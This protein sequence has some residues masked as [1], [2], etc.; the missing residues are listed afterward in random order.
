MA[1][2]PFFLAYSPNLPDQ[3]M[4]SLFKNGRFSFY[5]DQEPAGLLSNCSLWQTPSGDRLWLWGEAYGD[6]PGLSAKTYACEHAPLPAGNE[7]AAVFASAFFSAFRQNRAEALLRQTNGA[8]ALALWD[9]QGREL[10]FFTDPAG[11]QRIYLYASEHELAWSDRLRDFKVLPTSWS[12]DQAALNG[13]LQKGYLSGETTWLQGVRLLKAAIHETF[14]WKDGRIERTAQKRY[15]Q[16]PAPLPPDEAPDFDE[17]V[18]EAEYLLRGSVRRTLQAGKHCGILLSGG[19]DSRL[20]LAMALKEGFKPDGLT[21]G[22][23]ES[24]DLQTAAQV[25]RLAGIAFK[26]AV[27]TPENWLQKHRQACLLTDGMVNVLHLHEAP[28]LPEWVSEYELLI[29]GI[30]IE[31]VLGG[32]WHGHL[33]KQPLLTK[34]RGQALP[35][36]F[37]SDEAYYYNNTRIG[38]LMDRRIRHFTLIANQLLVHYTRRLMP[39][40][41]INF[42]R[43]MLQLPDSYRKHYRLFFHLALRYY[44]AFFRDIPWAKTGLPISHP[45]TRPLLH[46]HWPGIR[47]LLFGP[48]DAI[49]PYDQ[50]LRQEPAHSFIR[51][52][53]QLSKSRLAAHIGSNPFGESPKR[54]ENLFRTLT[55]EWILRFFHL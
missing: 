1:E 2:R 12:L 14:A 46:L 22:A 45:L 53:L 23:T 28:F 4:L 41:D 52:E 11:F 16:W 54:A 15:W 34:L 31:V 35:K 24:K 8:F 6:F 50:W 32:L 13:F 33:D 51:N 37:A 42:L 27:L 10:H 19:L 39:F 40:A 3:S 18:E 30:A 20:I 49:A 5:P 21:L 17:A 9:A 44:P 36:S 29:D 7:R 43:F 38:F 55:A 26:P 47:T 25:A 48:R